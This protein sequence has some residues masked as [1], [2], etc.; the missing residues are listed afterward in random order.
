[1]KSPMEAT[2]DFYFSKI[3][4]ADLELWKEVWIA[5][6][7]KKRTRYRNKAE[8]QLVYEMVIDYAE[9]DDPDNLEIHHYEG[10]LERALRSRRQGAGYQAHSDGTKFFDGLVIGRTWQVWRDGDKVFEHTDVAMA[11]SWIINNP[12]E[13]TPDEQSEEPSASP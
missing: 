4:A 5:G 13:T 7:K 10:T 2:A 1:M 3:M 11:I 6:T 8:P 9:P 12:E